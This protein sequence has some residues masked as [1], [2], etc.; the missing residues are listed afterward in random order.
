MFCDA[1]LVFLTQ[2][3]I[4]LLADPSSAVLTG[5]DA[6]VAAEYLTKIRTAAD[7]HAPGCGT[8]IG[9]SRT[10][11]FLIDPDNAGARER[12]QINDAAYLSKRATVPLYTC[13]LTTCK[14]PNCQYAQIR[15]PAGLDPSQVPQFITITFD[16]AVNAVTYAPTTQL[17]QG[18][19]NP[20]GCEANGTYYVSAQ[21]TDWHA[22]QTLYAAGHE[23][24]DHTFSH[25]VPSTKA[26]ISSLVESL[27]ALAMIPRSAIQGFRAPFLKIST[28]TIDTLRALNFSYDSSI[29]VTPIAGKTLWPFTLDAGVPVNCKV[30]DCSEAIPKPDGTRSKWSAPGIWELPMYTLVMPNGND[31]AVMDPS[32]SGA[33]LMDVLD[34]NFDLH[35]TGSRAPFG[36]YLHGAWL[37]SDPMPSGTVRA[38][39]DKVQMRGNVY[40]VSNA[41]MLEWL[42]NP[43]PVS[44]MGAG[45][46]CPGSTMTRGPEVCDGLDNDGNGVADD[47]I[48]RTCRHPNAVFGTC[49]TGCP[50]RAPS[51]TE[52]VPPLTDPGTKCVEPMGTCGNGIWDAT[53]CLCKCTGTEEGS[54]RCRDALGSCSIA[55][56]LVS[57][58]CARCAYSPAPV[59]TGTSSAGSGGTSAG[60]ANNDSAAGNVAMQTVEKMHGMTIAMCASVVGMVLA[61]VVGAA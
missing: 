60:K 46:P 33:N 36:L 43:Q 12:R 41:Q 9:T 21:Y 4:P 37:L 32:L 19:K 14:L 3:T 34:R 7:E 51:V 8:G 54:G 57:G 49:A 24:A 45:L 30:G 42:R 20:D 29:G 61:I 50:V 58:R 23:I 38:L 48:M 11:A 40:I 13:D 15:P 2:H 16:D 22:V 31:Y 44:S 1:K 25:V 59:V 28:A 47:G 27:S 53:K 17:L 35:Y 26:E 52:P 39:L 5:L 55:K 18:I 56:K 6:N 10:A